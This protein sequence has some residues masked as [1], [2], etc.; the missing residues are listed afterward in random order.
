MIITHQITQNKVKIA[1]IASL[2]FIQFIRFIKCRVVHC[3]LC[4]LFINLQDVEFTDTV[5]DVVLYLR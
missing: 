5:C 2:S 1:F 4:M 3:D